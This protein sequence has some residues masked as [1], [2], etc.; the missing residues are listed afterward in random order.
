MKLERKQSH[1]Q[2][3][4]E[5]QK[6][7]YDFDFSMYEKE[8]EEQKVPTTMKDLKKPPVTGLRN[9]YAP[10]DKV[11][12]QLAEVSLEVSK[13]AIKTAART[14]NLKEL[15]TF[16]AVLDELWELI[17]H[18]FGKVLNDDMDKIKKV[19][20]KLLR[21]ANEENTIPPKTYAFLLHFRSKIYQLKQVANF[22][23]E[24]EK[25]RGGIFGRTRKKITE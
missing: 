2:K 8:E 17:R 12:E 5:E 20:K 22:S 4:Q 18:I 16:Y 23:F 19:C 10:W 6:E 13:Y 15:W 1:K 21:K 9:R 14:Q 11:N 3:Q 7:D 24:V 25:A